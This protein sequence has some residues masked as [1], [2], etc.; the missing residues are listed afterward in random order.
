MMVIFFIFENESLSIMFTYQQLRILI[1]AFIRSVKKQQQNKETKPNNT[2]NKH[3]KENLW[4][5]LYMLLN[6]KQN[7]TIFLWFCCQHICYDT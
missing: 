2:N 5:F 7:Y 1:I 4:T 3:L 6:Y